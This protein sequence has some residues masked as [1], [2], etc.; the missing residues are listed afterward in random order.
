[1]SLCSH[2]SLCV[3]GR[4]KRNFFSHFKK[5][6]SDALEEK[7]PSDFGCQKSRWMSVGVGF[8]LRHNP[9]YN[10]FNYL[11]KLICRW[12]IKQ[13]NEVYELM[14]SKLGK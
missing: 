1:M 12:N 6:E 14:C 4:E 10:T 11:Q 7:S 5:S 2:R 8:G 3:N 13:A 9:I